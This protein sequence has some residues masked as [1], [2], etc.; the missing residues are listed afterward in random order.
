MPII[1]KEGTDTSAFSGLKRV[2]LTMSIVRDTSDAK[3]RCKVLC[4]VEELIHYARSAHK[5]QRTG[6]EVAQEPLGVPRPAAPK[7]LLW[8]F[9]AF[10]GAQRNVSDEQF[11]DLE[12][13]GPNSR[14]VPGVPEVARIGC[15]SVPVRLEGCGIPRGK[16]L[17]RY[18]ARFLVS[19]IH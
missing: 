14:K 2:T 17:Q 4:A 1:A 13:K 16:A 11:V 15:Q 8:V 9:V 19:A 12:T 10:R 7:H 5:D 6:S 3:L 18:S